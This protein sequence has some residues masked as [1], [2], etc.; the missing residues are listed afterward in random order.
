MEYSD[1]FETALNHA[2][3]YEVGPNWALTPDVEAGL[4]STR[5]QQKATGY[6]NDPADPGGETKFGIAKNSNPTVDIKALTFSEARDIYYA[7]YWVPGLCDKLSTRLALLHFDGCINIGV[8]RAKQLLQKAAGVTPD[9]VIGPVTLA[10]IT[11]KNDIDLCN[12]L[13]DARAAYYQQI[14]Q[15]RPASAKFLKGWLN[16]ITELRTFVQNLK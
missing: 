4:C 2:M 9:G 6:V 12:A 15:A 16:R 11:A 10:A 13:C 3:L 7:R 5:A 8:Q 1:S 14:V